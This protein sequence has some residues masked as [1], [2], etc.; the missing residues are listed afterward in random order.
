MQ[1]SNYNDLEKL[2]GL[3]KQKDINRQGI[4]FKTKYNN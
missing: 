4:L 1:Y 2:I 3:K